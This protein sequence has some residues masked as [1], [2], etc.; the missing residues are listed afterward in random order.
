LQ[1]GGDGGSANNP[2]NITNGLT[3]FSYV[4][5]NWYGQQVIAQITISGASYPA[6]VH[7]SVSNPQTHQV[8]APAGK[9]IIAFSGQTQ[10]VNLAGGGFTWVLA[11]LN[12]V[13]G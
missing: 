7:P 12:P 5:G 1:H 4:T 10:Y 8:T 9:S 13:F 11:Q 3:A 6:S 2:I